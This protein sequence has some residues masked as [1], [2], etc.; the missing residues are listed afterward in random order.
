MA[1]DQTESCER[2]S[3]AELT[4]AAEGLADD[5]LIDALSDHLESCSY[6]QSRMKPLL[7]GPGEM[8]QPG[9]D[10]A[11]AILGNPEPGDD[12][13]RI[14]IEPPRSRQL[15]AGECIGRYEVKGVLGRGASAVVYE[16][17]DAKLG[18]TV[19]VKVLSDFRFDRNRLSREA[20]V[21]AQLNHP[22]IVRVFEIELQQEPPY[23][24]MER[25][26]GG[27]ARQLL[28]RGPL[29]SRRAAQ[30]VEGVARTLHHAHE[31]GIIHRDIKPS[32]LL[33]SE[34]LDPPWIPSESLE[35][36]L[37]DFGLALPIADPSELTSTGAILGTPAYMSPEQTRGKSAT[38]DTRSDIYS[39]GILLHE[40]L[41]GRPPLVADNIVQTLR[42]IQEVE[43]LSPRLLNSE[44]P[45][46][47]E[48]ICLKCLQKTPSA[49]YQT[50][51]EMADDLRRYLDGRPITARPVGSL[52][53]M[54]RWCR[55]NPAL[56]ASQ[57]GILLLVLS[58]AILAGVFAIIQK[59]LRSRADETAELYRKAVQ[60]AGEDNDELRTVFD[61]II[62]IH[63]KLNKEM[64]FAPD[65]QTLAAIAKESQAFE[66]DFV[67]I[68]L[69]RAKIGEIS[70]NRAETTFRDA[71][72]LY[73]LNFP[74]AANELLD[75]IIATGL[76]IAP[77]DHDYARMR[78][79]TIQSAT[80]RGQALNETDH[81]DQAVELLSKIWRTY[82]YD[83]RLYEV[84]RL[85]LLFRREFL[86]V[87][88]TSFQ[89]TDPAREPEDWLAERQ[90]IVDSLANLAEKQSKSGQTAAPALGSASGA[91]MP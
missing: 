61:R 83:P 4:S 71:M 40:F 22:G 5:R 17:T 27:S 21:L 10:E 41:T 38:I 78:R 28:E 2:F 88:I 45:V 64:E 87:L 13:D 31:Q 76:A 25:V 66:L 58:F 82:P 84:E 75:R 65:A 32:N 11:R 14:E 8:N 60:E 20:R 62:R 80:R 29:P 26:P 6:C 69:E 91:T 35:L 68:L 72:G 1:V 55:R 51:L 46:D 16:C 34:P 3:D 52:E 48:T 47:L 79:L 81:A 19:A 85:D 89:K 9:G 36:K 59:G 43:P 42:M 15:M 7:F 53:K 56:A 24:V 37:S 57:A 49:R 54:V 63:H 50:A 12:A 74:D 86:N 30:L 33:M 23:L 73:F 67:K 70:A 90:R 77:G 44:I 18:R 39:L